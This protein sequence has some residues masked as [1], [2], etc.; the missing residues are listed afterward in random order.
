M[1]REGWRLIRSY[2]D[3]EL[4]GPSVVLG[5]P[6]FTRGGTSLIL[7]GSGSGK[8]LLGESWS[9]LLYQQTG[10]RP[11]YIATLDVGDDP[12]NE[13][14]VRRHREQ[15]AAI[16]FETI[17]LPRIQG[18]ELDQVP[19]GHPVLLDCLGN[20]TANQMFTPQDGP[21]S[22]APVFLS[23]EET[24][25]SIDKALTVLA[26][27][28][29]H[30]IVVSNLIFSDG[31]RYDEGTEGYLRALGLIHRRIAVRA[32][33][34]VEVDGGIPFFHKE[35]RPALPESASTGL[36]RSASRKGSTREG[37]D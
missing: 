27:K 5:Q 28:S 17:E 6:V 30:L 35:M 10:L 1:K 11:L 31:V 15:R 2:I 23:C 18:S 37:L 3:R 14:R 32:A 20:L 9:D 16:P 21:T 19:G 29:L 22:D 33:N 25:E 4:C 26:M 36:F 12:E 13:R 34:V 24:V 8:S 7:G